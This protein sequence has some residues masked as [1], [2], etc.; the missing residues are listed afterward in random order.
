MI[1]FC[2][3]TP[4]RKTAAEAERRD[5]ILRLIYDMKNYSHRD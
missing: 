4:V 3:G 1:V 5:Y 2:I